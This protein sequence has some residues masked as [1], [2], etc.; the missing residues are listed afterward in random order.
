MWQTVSLPNSE[1]PVRL[2]LATDID[3]LIELYGLVTNQLQLMGLRQWHK[4]YPGQEII[5]ADLHSGNLFLVE[6]EKRAIGVVV[7]DDNQHPQ[8]ADIDWKFKSGRVLVIHR[9]AVHPDFSGKGIAQALCR[10]CESVAKQE[11]YEH[12]RLDAYRGNIRSNIFYQKMGY[13]KT[14]RS[15]QFSYQDLPCDCYEKLIQ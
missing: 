6:Q 9:L 3:S 11:G 14:N 4:D 15:C 10:F 13:L 2:G 7:L 12:I 5:L 1:I 8:Y